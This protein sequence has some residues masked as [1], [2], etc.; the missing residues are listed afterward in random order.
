[1]RIHTLGP[2]GTFSHEAVQTLYPDAEILLCPNFDA[3]FDAV[4][5]TGDIGI[6]PIENSL[7]GSV[8]EVLDLLMAT[9]ARIWRMHDVAI[10]Q[11]LGAMNAA[12]V[13]RVASHPQALSQ[14]RAF[15]RKRFPLAER[16]AVSSTA[17]AIDLALTDPTVAAIASAKT[18]KQ[19]G[20]P[21]VEDDIQGK[22]NTTR[23]AVIAN[24]DPFPDVEKT[25]MSAVLHIHPG[26]DRPG[27]LHAL[28]T[29]FKIYDVN[30][31]RIESRPTGEKLG[32]YS[33]FVDFFGTRNSARVAALLKDMADIADIRV[34]GEW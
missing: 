23:F 3:V 12:K 5:R 17:Q 6:V 2:T 27:R 4:T 21:V 25:Q 20:L 8:D 28:L 29:P 33:F 32:D 22:N 16:F 26:D 19:R 10:H 30:L 1:M 15:L 7:H 24:A 34:L 18:M 13:T 31:S 9:S 11:A 14:C